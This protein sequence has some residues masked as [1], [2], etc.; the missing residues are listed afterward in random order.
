MRIGLTTEERLIVGALI[1]ANHRNLV[2]TH[3][4]REEQVMD[5]EKVTS[6]AVAVLMT[7][8]DVC[9]NPTETFDRCHC[10]NDDYLLTQ[11]RPKYSP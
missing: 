6:R 3:Y 1:Q 10:Q 8:L 4:D 11:T 5:N 7:A 2:E 9:R